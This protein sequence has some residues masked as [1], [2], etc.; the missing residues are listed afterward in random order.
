[1]TAYTDT[2]YL[3]ALYRQQD[4][5]QAAAEYLARIGTP[6]T[7]TALVRYEFVN[8]VRLEIFRNTAD[9]TRG[10]SEVEGLGHDCSIRAAP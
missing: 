1:M 6:L 2:S 10:Y 5:S 4:N 9:H 3:C 8:G 7:I